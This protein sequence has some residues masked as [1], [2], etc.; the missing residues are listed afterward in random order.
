MTTS[1]IRRCHWL[2]AYTVRYN[3]EGRS[4]CLRFWNN[5]QLTT[6]QACGDI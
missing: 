6:K 3:G 1:D 2:V 4:C 5:R